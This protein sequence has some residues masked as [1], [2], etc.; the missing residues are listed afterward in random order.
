MAGSGAVPTRRMM[1]G[2]LWLLVVV[3]M[4]S[5]A[6]GN[7]EENESAATKTCAKSIPQ[8]GISVSVEKRTKKVSF[9]C[10]N[11]VTKVV[12]S[13]EDKSEVTECYT[14]HTLR[15]KNTLTELFGQ[16]SQASVTAP[17]TADPKDTT[18][19]LTLAQL[20]EMTTD[21][22]FGC[23]ATTESTTTGTPSVLGAVPGTRVMTNAAT[24]ECVVTVTVPADPAANTCTVEK[25]NMELEINS[26]SKRVSFLCDTG[27][28]TLI[29]L[30]PSNKILD[31]SCQNE[32]MLADALPSAKFERTVKNYQFSVEE[33]PETAVTLCYKCSA[34][35]DSE[36]EQAAAEGSNACT[37]KIKVAAANHLSA[38]FHFVTTGSVLAVVLGV[39]VSV[40][41][42]P[43]GL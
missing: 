5:P 18:V 39:A 38:A 14:D 28:T 7:N 33:L 30:D 2:V 41:F 13:S 31:E 37:V 24:A 35:L 4:P 9:A 26:E 23:A 10:G 3:L 36:R 16:G 17:S 43:F 12:P 20:P 19:T 8:K 29:P 40:S 27:I 42:L 34:A 25:E 22:Y 1:A 32:V 11:G 6:L 15:T 21:I